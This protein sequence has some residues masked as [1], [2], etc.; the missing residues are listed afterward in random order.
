MRQT[1]HTLPILQKLGFIYHIDNLSRDEPSILNVNGKSFAVVP[2]T[3]RNNDIMRFANPSF[4]A[5]A[6]AQDLKD[7][8]DVLYAEAGTRRRLMSISVHDRI[9]GAPARVEAYSEFIAYALNHPGVVFMR[10]D[11]ITI[12]ALSQPDTPHD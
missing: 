11:E 10:K 4:T 3:E 2:Y 1:P 5:G 12:W 8:F 6:F 9:G 7:E